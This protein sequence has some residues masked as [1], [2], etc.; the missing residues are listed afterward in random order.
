MGGFM[1]KII[2]ITTRISRSEE[3]KNHKENHLEGINLIEVSS[4]YPNVIS[5]SGGIPLLIPVLETYDERTIH[6]I[7]QS[8]DGLLLTGGEDID[9]RLYLLE[10]IDIK[11][12]ELMKR[13]LERDSFE[14]ALLKEAFKLQMPILGICRG[15]Q[16]IN[17]CFGGSLYQDIERDLKSKINHLASL[18]DKTRL[19]HDVT[20][21]NDSVLNEIFHTTKL[22]VNSFH[23]QSI[24]K[25][26]KNF[27]SIAIS[28]DQVIEGVIYKGSQWILGIQWHPEMLYKKYNIHR[29][30]FERF[31]QVVNKNC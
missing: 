2:G 8:I 16:L 14:M 25:L 31:V 28:D 1:G 12:H 3:I 18:N 10:D 13:D 17:V 30:L 4:D 6:N 23:H 24:N 29:K 26:A 11:E 15:H 22:R 20:L 7:I 9:P 21:K 19:I 27:E 5:D